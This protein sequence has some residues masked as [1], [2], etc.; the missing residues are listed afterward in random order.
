[1]C[2]SD[3]LLSGSGI[4]EGN[5]KDFY[6]MCILAILPRS[7]Q[8]NIR[9]M[10]HHEK[11]LYMEDLWTILLPCLVF[12]EHDMK[13]IILVYCLGLLANVAND[14]CVKEKSHRCV[15][16]QTMRV[17]CPNKCMASGAFCLAYCFSW[18]SP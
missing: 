4:K 15:A 10:I 1:M 11:D 14:V 9:A 6:T 5:I 8:F 13:I 12:R 18:A 2:H 7:L 3:L 17:N 16:K